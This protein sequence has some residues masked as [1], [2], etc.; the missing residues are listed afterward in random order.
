M[1]LTD[2]GPWGSSEGIAMYIYKTAFTEN[3]MGYGSAK[4]HV[5][6]TFVILF[7]AL[8]LYLTSKGEADA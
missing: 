7:T 6:T 5:F 8:Q 2:G 1:A 3:S 4:S